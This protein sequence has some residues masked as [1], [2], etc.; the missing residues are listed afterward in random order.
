MG[1]ERN[2]RPGDFVFCNH[3]LLLKN[4][5]F[6]TQGHPASV[7]L[8]RSCHSD[9]CFSVQYFNSLVFIV[10]L[11]PLKKGD[12]ASCQLNSAVIG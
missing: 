9:V 7:D 10:Y 6:K 4:D 5:K 3:S 1:T 11:M 2:F 12:G 8:D